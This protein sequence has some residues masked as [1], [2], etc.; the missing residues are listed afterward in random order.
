[1]TNHTKPCPECQG[2]GTQTYERERRHSAS[3]DVGFIEEYE[4]DCENC[5]GVGL[6]DDDEEDD[7]G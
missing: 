2:S 4:D 3:R 1:M 5:G 6:I 7:N